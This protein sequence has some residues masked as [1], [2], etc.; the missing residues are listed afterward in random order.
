MEFPL[1]QDDSIDLG[2]LKLISK[3]KNLSLELSASSKL[4]PSLLRNGKF[5]YNCG[6][7]DIYRKTLQSDSYCTCTRICHECEIEQAIAEVFETGEFVASCKS[8]GENLQ[9]TQRNNF[10][11]SIE[12]LINLN[13]ELK[14][15]KSENSNLNLQLTRYKREITRKNIEF[16]KKCNEL[17]EKDKIIEKQNQ[18]LEI[19]DKEIKDKE[20]KDSKNFLSLKTQY[21]SQ[22][23]I[24]QSPLK[25]MKIIS[26]NL[27]DK[28][29]I[30]GSE[31]KKFELYIKSPIENQALNEKIDF[32][33]VGKIIPIPSPMIKTT[34]N[35][36]LN[37]KPEEPLLVD[38]RK[39]VNDRRNLP[40]FVPEIL[41]T[42]PKSSSSSKIEVGNKWKNLIDL[43]GTIDNEKTV[44]KPKISISAEPQVIGI[45]KKNIYIPDELD[46]IKSTISLRVSKEQ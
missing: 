9:I 17:E 6:C 34:K 38:I 29:E 3:T 39:P 14:D 42:S 1:T 44:K 43:C 10:I 24:N 26:T 36:I 31:D 4:K 18:N 16:E 20:I 15:I 28:I 13:K 12:Q 30:K 7:N 11:N 37:A 46:N 41:D 32:G 19:K 8:C 21:Q 22:K 33:R 27:A 5:P 40:N 25:P 2:L 23:E 35:S 45:N